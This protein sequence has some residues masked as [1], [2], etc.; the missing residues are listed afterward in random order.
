M[1]TSPV[2]NARALWRLAQRKERAVPKSPLPFC[3]A[4]SYADSYTLLSVDMVCF[5]CYVPISFA[6]SRAFSINLSSRVGRKQ[7]VPLSGHRLRAQIGV[8][9]GGGIA[10]I[11]AARSCPDA[12][13]FCA[14]FRA[15]KQANN[16]E[17]RQQ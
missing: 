16:S 10:A 6:R 5:C 12:V 1:C 11:F 9:F 4:P 3:D 7:T 2:F 15:D 8:H 13:V 14:G 17:F